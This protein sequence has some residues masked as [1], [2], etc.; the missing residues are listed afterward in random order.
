MLP[1]YPDKNN[2]LTYKI[3]KENRIWLIKKEKHYFFSNLFTILDVICN[4]CGINIFRPQFGF[5]SRY[6]S[7]SQFSGI[8]LASQDPQRHRVVESRNHQH[9][10][11]NTSQI[12]CVFCIGDCACLIQKFR[13]P[14]CLGDH[15]FCDHFSLYKHRLKITAVNMKLRISWVVRKISNLAKQIN[16]HGDIMYK[17]LI[18]SILYATLAK[19]RMHYGRI[20]VVCSAT[21]PSV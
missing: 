15:D 19:V 4:D 16:L 10:I 20:T 2:G 14:M 13:Q 6:P 17:H 8:H 3:I 7:P 5:F 21:I 11:C 18:D 12:K 1:N 9:W